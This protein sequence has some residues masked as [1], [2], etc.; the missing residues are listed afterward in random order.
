MVW[1]RNFEMSFSGGPGL[2]DIQVFTVEEG[3][4]ARGRARMN[5]KY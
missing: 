1:A 2:N 5:P 4:T 3:R